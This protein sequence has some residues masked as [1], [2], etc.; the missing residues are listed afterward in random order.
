M[1]KIYFLI[2]WLIIT[3]NKLNASLVA[4]I[5]TANHS[6]LSSPWNRKASILSE[7]IYLKHFDFKNLSPFVKKI[8]DDF[9][10]DELPNGSTIKETLNEKAGT[11]DKIRLAQALLLRDNKGDPERAVEIIKW[12]LSLQNPDETSIDFGGWKGSVNSNSYDQNWREF[13]GTDLVIIYHKYK[14]RLPSD[15]VT[16]LERCLIRTAK[17]DLIRN[18]NPD[19]NNISIMSSFLLEYIGTAFNI[20]E[21]RNAGIQKAKEIYSNFLKYNTLCEYNSPTYY[22]VDFFGLALWRELSFSQ[23]LKVLG[24]ILEKA[25]WLD[26]SEFYNANLQNI[27]GPY[28]RSYG[29]DMKKYNAITGVWIAAAVDNPEIATVPGKSG[30]TYE[31]SMIVSILNLGISMPLQAL[32]RLKEFDGPKFI[33][34]VTSNY[35]EGDRLKKVTATIKK[36]WMMGGLWGNRKVSHILKTGT[37]HW[38]STDED[39]SWLFIPGEGVTNVQVDEKQM[40]IYLADPQAKIFSILVYSKNI[41]SENFTDDLWKLLP[42]QLGIQSGLHRAEAEIVPQEEIDNEGISTKDYPNIMKVVYKIPDN[43]NPADPLLIINPKYK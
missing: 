43:W 15:V 10:E 4:L 27:C 32:S 20:P 12:I 25:L 41:S 35:Y 21:I 22:G 8:F 36:D 11:R 24:K 18:V 16:E 39:I 19:Y 1:R 14:T 33:S 2:F 6:T 28:L 3:G 26:L 7:D 17:G 9:V 38:K 29:M 23:E 5:K 37:I 13:V 40:K 31:Y 30:V 42:M 34:R